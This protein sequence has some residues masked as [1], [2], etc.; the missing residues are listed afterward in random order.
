MVRVE[1][2]ETRTDTPIIGAVG[3][4]ASAGA[5]NSFMGHIRAPNPPRFAI[6]E[7]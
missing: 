7:C 3:T 6:V 4:I 2:A 1:R 5:C